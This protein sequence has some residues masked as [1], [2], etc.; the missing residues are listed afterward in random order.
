MGQKDPFNIEGGIHHI[1]QCLLNLEALI[2]FGLHQIESSEPDE[3]KAMKSQW[4]T[5]MYM[6]QDQVKAAQKENGDIGVAAR[7]QRGSTEAHH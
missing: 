6:L 3:F 4:C 2:S 7:K 5:M 1:D